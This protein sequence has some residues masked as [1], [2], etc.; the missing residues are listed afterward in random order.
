VAACFKAPVLKFA[1]LY[2]GAITDVVSCA[3]PKNA[4]TEHRFWLRKPANFSA[5][6]SEQTREMAR[7]C[8]L[9]EE[10]H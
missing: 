2:G 3:T 5:S 7:L 4:E 8:T 9:L 1:G 6:R 10:A